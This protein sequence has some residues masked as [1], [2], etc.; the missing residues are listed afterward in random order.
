MSARAGRLYRRLDELE[1]EFRTLL[2]KELETELSGSGFSRYLA[3]KHLF[4][5][6]RWRN[7]SAAHLERL[8]KDIVRLREKLGEPLT[9]SAVGIALEYARVVPTLKVT[10]GEQKHLVKQLLDRLGGM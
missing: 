4:D 9:A 2:R 3:R 10:S 5:G 1:A 8:E 6:R 7:T